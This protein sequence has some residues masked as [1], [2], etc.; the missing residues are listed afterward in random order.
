MADRSEASTDLSVHVYGGLHKV[1][2]LPA[3]MV[4]KTWAIVSCCDSTA[5]KL[6]FFHQNVNNSFLRVF[7][8]TTDICVNGKK[9]GIFFLY[10]VDGRDLES[11]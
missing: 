6:D 10:F 7:S 4:R 8:H 1:L 3:T 11:K 9:K 5:S 2:T